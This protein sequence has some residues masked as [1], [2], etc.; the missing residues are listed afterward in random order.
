[1]KNSLGGHASVYFREAKHDL[2]HYSI[3]TLIFS[4]I[5]LQ[6]IY[7]SVSNGISC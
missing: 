4:C 2:Y 7:A 3:V 5:D 6:A 1:M